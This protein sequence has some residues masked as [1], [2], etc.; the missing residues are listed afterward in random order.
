MNDLKKL[1]KIFDEIGI[2]YISRPGEL[3][4]CEKAGDTTIIL[5]GDG[6]LGMWYEF[7]FLNGKLVSH[8]AWE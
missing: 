7:N 8:G 5:Q 2:K 3:G 1:T 4:Y 6:Y